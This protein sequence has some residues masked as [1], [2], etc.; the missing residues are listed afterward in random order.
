MDRIISLLLLVSLF[1]PL[2]VTAQERKFLIRF[3]RTE[4]LVRVGDTVP[5]ILRLDSDGIQ[6]NSADIR[7]TY[8][9]T[10]V[11]VEKITREQSIF[12]LWPEA[13]S[14]DEQAGTIRATGGRPNGA[15]VRDAAL[16]T[17]YFRATA[18]GEWA[19]SSAD[20]FRVYSNDSQPQPFSIQ[21][22]TV[23][24]TITD[25]LVS[26]ILLRSTSHPTPD[27]WSR[28]SVVDVSWEK[29]AETQYGFSFS[30]RADRVPSD[31]PQETSGTETFTDLDDG[32]YYFAIH[33]R[34]NGNW[35][36]VTRRR[37]LIDQTSPSAPAPT[38]IS[39]DQLAGRSAV[40]W[41]TEDVTSGIAQSTVTIGKKR[42]TSAS[43][44]LLIESSW[45]GKNMTITVTD[46]AGNEST[47]SL[48]LPGELAGLSVLTMVLLGVIGGG[49]L[50]FAIVF[51]SRRRS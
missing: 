42:I 9:T 36:S 15:V 19:L 18:S 4:G 30:D 47:S 23:R 29:E 7:L 14:W 3:E 44:P 2:H 34:K 13:P 6:I 37:F 12:S 20:A 24:G 22:T 39:A 38:I 45:S 1:V 49:L 10:K 28:R 51:W 21:P 5:V 33:A 41:V 16:L 26:G 50:I 46:Q 43:S 35:S 40:S 32:V 25:P 48:R 8:D 31:V 17:I 11:N 27:T